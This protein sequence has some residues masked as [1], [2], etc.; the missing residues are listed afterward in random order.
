[1]SEKSIKQ[2]TQVVDAIAEKFQKATSCVVVDYKGLTV[3]EDT[4]LRKLFREA[5]VDYKVYK[6]TMVRHAAKQVEGLD[7]FNDENLVG[8]NAFA[9]GYDDPIVPARIIKNFA[10]DHEKLEMKF[11]YVERQFYDSKKLEE[12][13]NIPPKE[14]LIAKLLGSFKAPMSNFVYMLSA[15]ADKKK[16]ESDAEAAPAENEQQAEQAPAAE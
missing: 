4:A 9:I 6:N 2:K 7:E 16:A 8:P 15:L 13:A 1:M 3:E 5:G 14:V 10:K 11:G 12:F